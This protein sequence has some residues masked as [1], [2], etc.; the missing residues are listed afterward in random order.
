MPRMP[1]VRVPTPI[2]IPPAPHPATLAYHLDVGVKNRF[3]G[4]TIERVT[5]SQDATWAGRIPTRR[6]ELLQS[7]GTTRGGTPHVSKARLPRSGCF[8]GSSSVEPIDAR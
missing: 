5:D 4:C 2:V 1:R 8:L 6:H 3:R 7:T